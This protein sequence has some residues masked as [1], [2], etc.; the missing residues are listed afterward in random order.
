M[1]PGSSHLELVVEDALD[2]ANPAG[3]ANCLSKKLL[4][5]KFELHL[6]FS[7]FSIVGRRVVNAAFVRTTQ[8]DSGTLSSWLSVL[9]IIAHAPFYFS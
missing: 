8:Q 7:V 5:S 2:R 4:L 9:A 3:C 6:L 1:P